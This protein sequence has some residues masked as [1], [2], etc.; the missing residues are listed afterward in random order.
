MLNIYMYCYSWQLILYC[1]LQFQR[2]L[3]LLTET[4]DEIKVIN[5]KEIMNHDDVEDLATEI[6]ES[7]K[8]SFAMELKLVRL[9]KTTRRTT[10]YT[11]WERTAGDV[12]I[13]TWTTTD[14]NGRNAES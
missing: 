1:E 13:I 14:D 9:E 6:F 7:K 10:N 11:Y 5:E 4:A 8:Y 3:R 12:E 2:L